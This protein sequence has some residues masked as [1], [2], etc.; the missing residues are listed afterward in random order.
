MVGEE[1][2]ARASGDPR[3]AEVGEEEASRLPEVG[4][5]HAMPPHVRCHGSLPRL[6]HRIH[7]I[8]ALVGVGPMGR[9]PL[10]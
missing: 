5:G 7:G 10:C 1:E 9:A 4:E 2:A 8:A 6:P 3:A